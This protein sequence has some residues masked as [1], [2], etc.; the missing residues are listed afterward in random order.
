MSHDE[1]V[2]LM[3]LELIPMYASL[4]NTR[5]E[6]LIEDDEELAILQYAANPP[7]SYPEDTYVP[8]EWSGRYVPTRRQLELER[9]ATMLIKY[10]HFDEV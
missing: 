3:T 9:E 4:E 2:E 1:I 8:S 10:G 6:A 5:V 7:D